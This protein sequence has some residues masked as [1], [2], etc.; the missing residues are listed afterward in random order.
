M[1]IIFN[2]QTEKT[3]AE[4]NINKKTKLTFLEQLCMDHLV[5]AMNIFSELGKLHPDE[6]RDAENAIHKMQGILYHL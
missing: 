4:K 3:M 2:N 6:L 1:K 5:A